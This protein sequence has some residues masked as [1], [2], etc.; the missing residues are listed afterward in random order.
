M[1]IQFF[2]TGFYLD[3]LPLYIVIFSNLSLIAY[4][5]LSIYS[6]AK[7]TQLEVTSLNLEQERENNRILQSSQDELHGF[8]HDFSNILCTIGGYVQMKDMNG[9]SNYYSQI[10]KDVTKI[11]NLGALNPS[12][13]NNPAVFVLISS[14][15]ILVTIS[16][17]NSFS[18]FFLAKH[19]ISLFFKFG[20]SR[21]R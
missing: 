20:K 6:L 8:R 7:A 19:P 13:I 14:K 5:I 10:Q 3:R 11:N 15:Y 21:K 18:I 1:S 17:L 2:V 16:L 9:L 12:S 4:F